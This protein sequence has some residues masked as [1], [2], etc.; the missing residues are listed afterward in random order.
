MKLKIHSFLLMFCVGHS[1]LAQVDKEVSFHSSHQ[2]ITLMGTIT[3]PE[4]MEPLAV[5]V[6]L[7][8]AGP[9]DR[10]LTLGN[11]KY[12][13]TLAD[14]LALEGIASIRYDDRGVGKSQGEFFQTT[15]KDRTADAC[16]AIKE[17]QSGFPEVEKTGFIGMS[18]GAGISVL[19]DELCGPVSF[20]ILLSTPVRKGMTE[21]EGQLLR[22]LDSGNFTEENKPRIKDKA[23]YFLSLVSD[24]DPSKNQEA[25][26]DLLKGPYGNVVLPPYGF[27]PKSPEEKTDFVLSPWYQS[28]LNYDIQFAL[29]KCETPA[30][31][32]YGEIDKAIDPVSNSELMQQL[33]PGI[34]V[35]ILPG[36]NHLMQERNSGWPMEYIFL[37]N[38]F[39][40]RVILIL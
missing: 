9:T 23:M 1:C 17:I 25:I 7:P 12:Y 27:V 14:S 34:K 22:L 32:L 2:G 29:K 11:H 30:L 20:L 21:M 28:Q 6:L 4:N 16:S 5:V 31:A 33:S 10:D 38:S 26:Y 24:Y 3:F 39:S 13:K 35:E 8:V 15:L 36:I 19:A 40:E 37:P 18:E